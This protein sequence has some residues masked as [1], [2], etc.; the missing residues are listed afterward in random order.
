MTAGPDYVFEVDVDDS[1]IVSAG[2]F[3]YREDYHL[4]EDIVEDVQRL[5]DVDEETAQGLLDET[6]N[7]FDHG[8]DGDD[9]WHLQTLTAE[10]AHR[11]GYLGVSA[12]DE[13][14][15]VYIL[16]APS[17][18]PRM[19]LQ[20][21]N[22]REGSPIDLRQARTADGPHKPR[23]FAWY[24]GLAD[25]AGAFADAISAAALAPL[26]AA[27]L[28]AAQSESEYAAEDT[29][30]DLGFYSHDLN[31]YAERGTAKLIELSSRA[32][33]LVEGMKT[34]DYWY[35]AQYL[36]YLRD[37]FGYYLE[38]EKD[39]LLH[40]ADEIEER[41]QD[42][43]LEQSR[44]Y[45]ERYP[46]DYGTFT[47]EVLD[48]YAALP[49]HFRSVVAWAEESAAKLDAAVERIG[50]YTDDPPPVEDVKVLYH[51]SLNSKE[52]HADGFSD[53]SS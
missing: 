2:S 14:G 23:T 13:Q 3:F 44:S 8:G 10:A 25:K 52:L 1:E 27:N 9:S 11:L 22:T 35:R 21:S 50:K 28:A 18:I 32:R 4:L 7:I 34:E 38:F 48:N 6:E 17:V 36:R 46:E 39:V 42:Y 29:L 43:I 5:Y 33:E 53:G 12:R 15:T 16:H 19:V 49:E 24:E 47:D 45:R 30:K 41:L 26:Q 40:W 37:H 51:A 31:N 20:D